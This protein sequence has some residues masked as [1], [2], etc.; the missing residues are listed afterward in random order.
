MNL[1]WPAQRNAF[2]QTTYV[3]DCK[4][5]RKKQC[6]HHIAKKKKI[7]V[8]WI[9]IVQK[10]IWFSWNINLPQ[11]I[12]NKPNTTRALKAVPIFLFIVFFLIQTDATYSLSISVHFQKGQVWDDPWVTRWRWRGTPI[13]IL[14]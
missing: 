9:I 14:T 5:K 12:R 2:E 6:S 4:Q 3:W 10:Y 13:R 7:N 8:T 11:F 1:S